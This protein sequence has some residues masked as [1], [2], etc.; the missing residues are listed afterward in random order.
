MGHEIYLWGS[1]CCLQ[2]LL[3]TR[4][5]LGYWLCFKCHEFCI[6]SQLRFSYEKKYETKVDSGITKIGPLYGW[7]FSPNGWIFRETPNGLWTPPPPFREKILCFFTYLILVKHKPQYVQKICNEVFRIGK[8]PPLS[9]SEFFSENSFSLVRGQVY[10]HSM[11]STAL[12]C[13]INLSSKIAG[14]QI[15]IQQFLLPRLAL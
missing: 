10:L 6:T 4:V 7:L 14:I 8:D 1:T 13:D 12:C 15:S 11:R 9:P 2:N 5:V 3:E